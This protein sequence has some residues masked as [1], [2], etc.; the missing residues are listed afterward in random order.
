MQNLL[1]QIK[2]FTICKSYLD[3]GANPVVTGHQNS[4][5]AIKFGEEHS[6]VLKLENDK[7]RSCAKCKSE[8]SA[9]NSNTPTWATWVAIGKLKVK[10]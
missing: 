3:L 10:H 6:L 8:Y 5:I 9:R 4:K 1:S 2:N 7:G